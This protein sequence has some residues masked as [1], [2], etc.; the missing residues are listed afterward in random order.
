MIIDGFAT[1]AGTQRFAERHDGLAFNL[2]G[3][4]GLS[5]S[6]AGFGSYRV[7]TENDIQRNALVAALQSGLNLIDTSANYG[8]G[9]AELLIGQVLSQLVD[10]GE[11]SRDEIVLVSKAGYL[12]GQNLALSQERK[13]VC[14]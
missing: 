7:S 1:P 3:R 6:P 2:L 8:D 12:Q 4:T 5:T 13:A 14:R 10:Q 11:I 9:G